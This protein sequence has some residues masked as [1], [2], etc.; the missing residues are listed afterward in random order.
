VTTDALE[1]DVFDADVFDADVLDADV[2]DASADI[3]L[4][5]NIIPFYL[6]F[7]RSLSMR[8]DLNFINWN[9]NLK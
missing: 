7:N 1:A 4:E 6:F 3:V 9:L 8:F 5:I 2:F